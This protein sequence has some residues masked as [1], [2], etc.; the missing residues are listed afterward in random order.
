MKKLLSSMLA[1]LIALGSASAFAAGATN[2][3]SAAT[4]Q[5]DV[6]KDGTM[7]IQDAT[8]IQKFIANLTDF[9]GDSLIAADVDGDGEVMIN[10]ATCVQKLLVSM[11][12]K[13]DLKSAESDNSIKQKGNLAMSN[14]AANLLKTSVKQGEN[15]L[16]SPLSVMYALSMTANGAVGDTLKEMENTLGLSNY[17]LNRYF[18]MYPGF[19]KYNYGNDTENELSI[20]NSIWFNKANGMPSISRSFLRSSQ[21]FYKAD[22]YPVLFNNSALNQINGWVNE[23]THNMI[24][25]ILDDIDPTSLMYLINAIAFEAEWQEQYPESAVIKDTFTPEAGKN[26]TVDYLRSNEDYYIS[27]GDL[28]KGFVKYYRGKNYAF[29]ALLPNEGVSISSYVQSLTGNRILSALNSQKEKSGKVYALLPKFEVEY[30][31]LLND[32]LQSMGMNIPFGGDANFSRMLS[33]PA[34]ASLSISRV[35]HKT[36]IQLNEVGTKAAAATVVEMKET[37]VP[38]DGEEP[39]KIYLTRPFV[40]MLINTDTN[41]PMFIGT[42]ETLPDTQS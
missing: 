38:P 19:L 15:T 41:T 6:D 12:R 31:D 33:N 1:A 26:V 23:K 13:E 28:A 2:T 22:I 16:V 40:Y 10:D 42:I 9:S 32:N 36:Y 4:V 8:D 3:S 17:E 21:D 35:I 39:I 30:D 5:A 25:T 14:F 20:A 34:S 37:C 7:S 24:P 27:D 29:A 18:Y 11:I